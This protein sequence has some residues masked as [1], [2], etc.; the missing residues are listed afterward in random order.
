MK[1]L[2]L[3]LPP[4]L[5]DTF[6]FQEI[7][8]ITDCMGILD[9][10]TPYRGKVSRTDPY[11]P[12]NGPHM[13]TTWLRTSDVISGTKERILQIYN[14]QKRA[15]DAGFVL[16]GTGPVA[17]MI[18][19]DM[20]DVSDAISQIDGLP[21][22]PVELGGHKYYDFG[23]SE[24]LLAMAKL[25][26]KPFEKQSRCINLIGGNAIDWTGENVRSVK[27]WAQDCGY[28][29]V[30]VWGGRETS[31]NLAKA[32]K[33]EINLVTAISGL[34]TAKWLKKEF[35]TD[36]I[37]AAPFGK[38]YTKTVLESLHSGA[39]PKTL[40]NASSPQVLIVGEQLM[41]NAIR[42]TLNSDYGYDSVQVATFFTFDKSLSLPYD[43]RLK[44]EQALKELMEGGNYDMIIA[45]P[46]LRVFRPDG[47]KW[48]D[49]PHGAVCYE[50]DGEPL[51]ALVGE[52]LNR[53]LDERI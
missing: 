26:V 52:E 32:A 11:E 36:Y 14:E 20:E 45:D 37:C 49:L 28:N 6:G 3:Y 46:D 15:F 50:F 10:C 38:S 24:T 8:D 47:C 16:V 33:A 4:L 30:S 17:S 22:A 25:L 18:G 41:S 1:N 34:A 53:W 19:T 13:V 29:V 39:Q 48:I 31:D 44:G 43:K 2:Y 12:Y 21:V 40:D 9:D 51:P 35:G 23:I 42:A 27:S 7:C 5:S